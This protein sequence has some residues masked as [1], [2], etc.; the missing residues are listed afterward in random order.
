MDFDLDLGYYVRV[1]VRHWKAVVVVFVVAT[2]VAAVVSFFQEP[3]YQATV[4]LTEQSFEFYDEPRLV[5]LDRT[6][7]KLYPTMA[8]TEAVEA[9]VIEAVDASLSLEEKT[10]GVLLSKVAVREDKDNPA[11][12]RISVEAANPQKAVLIANTWAEEY[13]DE[14]ASY[15]VNWDPQLLAAEAALEAAEDELRDFRAQTGLIVVE[16]SDGETVVA[17]MGSRGAELEKMLD[18]L[19]EHRLASDYL[20]LLVESARLARDTGGEVEDLPLHLLNTSVISQRGLVTEEAV[21]GLSSM[22]SIIRVLESEAE[23]IEAAEG[24]LTR[25]VEEL[26]QDL[27]EDQLESERLTRARDL[28]ENAYKA[29]VKEMQEASLFQTKTEILSRATRAKSVGSHP[30]LNVILGAA[31]GLAGGVLAAFAL[32]YAEQARNRV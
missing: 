6:V 3:T 4:T 23:L 9:R 5:S 14:V 1:V 16:E 25:G 19:A 30:L 32:Q 12:F 2:V 24:Q 21:G 18:S 26:Q 15:Q 28:A 22:D 17:T 8:R 11:I 31:L 13:L 27:A 10:P 20:R 29:V 7:I